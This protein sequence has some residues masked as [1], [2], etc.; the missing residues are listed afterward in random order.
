MTN[1]RAKGAGG[2][3]TTALVADVS[4]KVE[5][6]RT[7]ATVEEKG[8]CVQQFLRWPTGSPNIYRLVDTMIPDEFNRWVMLRAPVRSL[9]IVHFG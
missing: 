8:D 7:S 6:A 9:R 4:E 1:S 2:A 5:V 3:T